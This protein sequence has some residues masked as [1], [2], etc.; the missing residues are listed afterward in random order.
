MKPRFGELHPTAARASRA[1]C[2]AMPS[3]GTTSQASQPV[4]PSFGRILT[5]PALSL[6]QN[7]ERF[8]CSGFIR[9]ILIGQLLLF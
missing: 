8:T 6:V 4:K 3:T 9:D 5:L 1:A 7:P 2:T